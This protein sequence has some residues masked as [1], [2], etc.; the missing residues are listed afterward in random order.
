MENRTESHMGSPPPSAHGGANGGR[1]AA[2]ASAQGLPHPAP[3]RGRAR[4]NSPR[5]NGGSCMPPPR[6]NGN[7]GNGNCMP[8]PR[9]NGNG[10]NGNGN[11]GDL[12][13]MAQTITFP[14][15]T[16]SWKSFTFPGQKRKSSGGGG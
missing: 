14:A 7:G 4:T 9:C 6:C 1:G 8:P 13:A 2:D 5:H 11:C 3:T 10:G 12:D 15:T 16:R